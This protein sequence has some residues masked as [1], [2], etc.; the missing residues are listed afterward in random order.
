[1][2]DFEPAVGTSLPGP[3]TAEL[4]AFL[5]GYGLTLSDDRVRRLRA[6]E[7]NVNLYVASGRQEF[8]LRRYDVTPPAEVMWELDLVDRLWSAYFPTAPV[9]RRRDGGLCAPLHGRIGALFVFVRG[10]HPRRHALWAGE[11]VACFNQ[12]LAAVGYEPKGEH[13]VSGRRYFRKGGD[14]RTHHVHVYEGGNPEIMRHLAFRDYL[15]THAE[16]ARRYG[17]VKQA[18]ARQFPHAA[19]IEALLRTLHL[20]R[21]LARHQ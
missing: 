5:D 8:V 21:A 3:A 11:Q 14:R 1:M 18:L 19:R 13:G 15:R 10:V 7:Y 12:P 16:D 20:P 4:R 9:T 17:E 2:P 6:S